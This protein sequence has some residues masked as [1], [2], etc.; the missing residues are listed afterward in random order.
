[1]TRSGAVVVSPK[2][3]EKREKTKEEEKIKSNL[4]EGNF[5]LL[6][7]EN[8]EMDTFPKTVRRTKRQILEDSNKPLDEE[9]Y[10]RL[11]YPQR[12]TNPKQERQYERFLDVFKKLQIN[13]PFAK[14][15][16]QMPS[17]AKFM[18]ELLSKKR[19]LENDKTIP[20]TE[21]CSAILQR[22]LPQ[23]LKDPGS[24]SIPC[25]IGNCTIG[26]ALCDLGASINLMP[27][28][29]MKRL[30]IEEVK[31][32]SITLQLADRSYTYPYGIV[33]D[34]IDVQKG[35]LMLRVQDENVTF[36][37]FEALK[38]PSDNSTA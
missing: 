26:K 6:K 27:L 24:F 20:L 14:A 11:L 13:I 33:E 22:K 1:M 16:E 28:A 21:E 4:E 10:K 35:K 3:A 8:S 5:T 29:I 18:K 31:P 30:G 9:K 37:V 32:T 34:L 17:Y 38:H 12:V 23:K 7:R 36:N 25:S 19:K 2:P 15:L